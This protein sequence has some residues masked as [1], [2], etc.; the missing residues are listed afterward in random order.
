MKKLLPLL[1][2]ALGVG[3]TPNSNVQDARVQTE[4]K[5][6]FSGTF[7]MMNQLST[8]RTG[9]KVFDN[10]CITEWGDIPCDTLSY[11]D[12]NVIKYESYFSDHID[13]TLAIIEAKHDYQEALKF[14][15]LYSQKELDK[16]KDNWRKFE[17]DD[18]LRLTKENELRL[19]VDNKEG[20][21][22]IAYLIYP[23]TVCANFI[24][25]NETKCF[26]N[27]YSYVDIESN[28][29]DTF[30]ILGVDLNLYKSTHEYKNFLTELPLV[31]K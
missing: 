16:L 18:S 27:G 11:Y 10:I 31:N 13:N 24:R 9:E 17:I 12:I 30:L 7:G 29:I 20:I 19:K 5:L 28:R 2:V 6:Q 14:G 26:E 25:M 22:R 1:L 23:F 3:C 15:D 4:E 21:D 8:E